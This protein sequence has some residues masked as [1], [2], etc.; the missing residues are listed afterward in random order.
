[1]IKVTKIIIALGLVVA[2]AFSTGC[3]KDCDGAADNMVKI[4]GGD[5]LPDDKKDE[6]KKAFAEA[7][8]KDLSK[9]NVNCIKEAKKKEDLAKC[10]P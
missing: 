4:M 3:G 9:D 5:K 6:A 7:C 10:E 2:M 1:V 8:E